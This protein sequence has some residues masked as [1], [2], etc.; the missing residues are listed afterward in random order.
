M[1]IMFFVSIN[2]QI[3]F[4]GSVDLLLPPPDGAVARLWESL[5]AC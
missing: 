3:L 5:T 2:F 1:Q 4:E